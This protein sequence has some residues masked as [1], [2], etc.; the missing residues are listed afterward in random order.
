[1]TGSAE[2]E[3]PKHPMIGVGAVVWHDGR[4][5]LIRRGKP[6]RAGEWSL[7]GGAQELGE[8]VQQTVQREVLE[9]TGIRITNI[10]FLEIVDLIM[11]GGANGKPRYH[12]TLLDFSADAN[13]ETTIPIPGDDASEAIWADADTLGDYNLWPVTRQVIEKSRK[14]RGH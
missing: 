6:P 1:M 2:R 4:V 5:L 10:E 9:E 14:L 8:T 13:S 11:P 7:P 3:N 12:Y